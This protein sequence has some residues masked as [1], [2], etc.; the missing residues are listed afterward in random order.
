MNKYIKYWWFR[1]AKWWQFWYPQ[2]GFC[3]G[4]ILGCVV[5]VVLIIISQL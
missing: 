3:G 2:S 1:E 4:F 5:V